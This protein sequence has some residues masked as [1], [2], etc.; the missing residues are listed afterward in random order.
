MPGIFR[1][2]LNAG[3][4]GQHD[5]VGQGNL[6]P[7]GLGAVEFLLDAFQR[8]QHFFQLRGIVHRPVLLRGET[9]ACAIGAAAFIGPAESRGRS[10]GGGYQLRY[11]QSRGQYF[12]FQGS[13]VFF[14][15]Q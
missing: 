7:A 13:N 10:P 4:T 11:R 9:E 12:G 15:D 5:H 8:F 3:A 14:V 1:G 6:F 2:F